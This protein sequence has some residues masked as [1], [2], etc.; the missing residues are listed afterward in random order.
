M[1]FINRL[2]LLRGLDQAKTNHERSMEYA[3]RDNPPTF[4]KKI[5]T[6]LDVPTNVGRLEYL[7]V[8]N[9]L[10][11]EEEYAKTQR[12][13]SPFTFHDDYV[14]TRLLADVRVLDEAYNQ[15]TKQ[16]PKSAVPSDNPTRTHKNTVEQHRKE[17][18]VRP[19][20]DAVAVKPFR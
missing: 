16:A 18:E 10:D 5:H 3:Y 15:Y 17:G 14:I 8:K 1:G 4:W 12:N 2:R 13:K 7:L 9:L 6:I 11:Y 19:R 20:S